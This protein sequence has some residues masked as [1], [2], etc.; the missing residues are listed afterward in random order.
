MIEDSD[1]L[2]GSRFKNT[3]VKKKTRNILPTC[4][5]WFEKIGI[6]GEASHSV[7]NQGGTVGGRPYA[8]L[9]APLCARGPPNN[10]TPSKSKPL[11]RGA[12][13]GGVLR[14]SWGS[15]VC[16]GASPDIPHPAIN[17]RFRGTHPGRRPYVA[18]GAALCPGAA[19]WD[20]PPK[21]N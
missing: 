2:K 16:P 17:L 21:A 3:N 18:K 15:L 6:R 11:K 10:P 1:L 14:G 8:A 13:K 9:G 20:E 12:M 4:H 19:D 7:W 5:G